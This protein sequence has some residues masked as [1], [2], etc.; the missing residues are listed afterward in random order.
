MNTMNTFFIILFRTKSLQ[1][2]F[3]CINIKR[4]NYKDA[5]SQYSRI[6]QNVPTLE[7]SGLGNTFKKLHQITGS[8]DNRENYVFGL[9]YILLSFNY[10]G[11][12]MTF[13]CCLLLLLLS[14]LVLAQY[15][16]FKLM[17]S[18]N[19]TQSIREINTV[20]LIKCTEVLEI[21]V[22]INQ[23]R[24]CYQLLHGKVG[25]VHHHSSYYI[26]Q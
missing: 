1:S 19:E 10:F 16:K 24:I 2:W 8:S 5:L 13:G 7:E 25:T 22:H 26:L 3:R 23:I 21:K 6:I 4:S 17:S 11:D 9:A 14:V 18:P 12:A 20:F 15:L